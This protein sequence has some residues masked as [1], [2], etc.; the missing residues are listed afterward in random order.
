M[1]GSMMNSL[2][3]G[4]RTPEPEVGMGATILMWSDRK[5]ATI[6][7]VLR[8]KTG[9]NKGQIK[10]VKARPCRA[11]RTDSNG[12]SDAQSYEY[13]E[14]PDWPESE[15]TLRQDGSFRKKGDK[16]TTLAIGFRSAYYD[17]SF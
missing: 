11:I 17:Y 6:T 5:P 7:E 15:W 9:P 12:M 13:E 4:S 14:M 2:M 16:Y 3:S 10:G 8:Y 1:Y